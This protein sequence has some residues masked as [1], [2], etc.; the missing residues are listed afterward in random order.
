MVHQLMKMDL[1]FSQLKMK[2]T[3]QLWLTPQMLIALSWTL[4]L[5]HLLQMLRHHKE[6]NIVKNCHSQQSRIRKLLVAAATPAQE[7][8]GQ[9]CST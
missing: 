2:V 6:K 1:L 3:E 5:L 8:K 9:S 7:N 4:P